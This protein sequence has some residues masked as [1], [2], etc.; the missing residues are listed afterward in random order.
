MSI[1]SESVWMDLLHLCPKNPAQ[2]A[3]KGPHHRFPIWS[4]PAILRVRS[5][6]S[7][8]NLSSFES[9]SGKDVRGASDHEFP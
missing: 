1:V 9:G 7:I 2:D 5:M 8:M 6:C 3:D 4:Q